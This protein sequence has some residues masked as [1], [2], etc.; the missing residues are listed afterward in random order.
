MSGGVTLK[1]VRHSVIGF[2]VW[3]RHFDE[4][5][6]KDIGYAIRC[7]RNVSD[8]VILSAGFIDWDAHGLP[9]CHGAS[10]SLNQAARDD[11]TAA[12]CAEWGMGSPAPLP[13]LAPALQADAASF[14]ATACLDDQSLEH[15]DPS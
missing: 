4:L 9:F 3:P 10:I 11:D 8:G 5:A 12:L 14:A 6:H 1:Y 7:S 13:A 15:G 2:V